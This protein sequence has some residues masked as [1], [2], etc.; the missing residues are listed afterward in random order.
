MCRRFLSAAVPANTSSS[1]NTALQQ[2]QQ[3]QWQGV[4]G[5]AAAGSSRGGSSGSSSV[6]SFP[7]WV[8]G[9]ARGSCNTVFTEQVRGQRREEE[10]QLRL[11]I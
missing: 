6:V 10:K 2:Q 9:I 1:S 4:R 5:P 7:S 8:R 3:Q 11:R